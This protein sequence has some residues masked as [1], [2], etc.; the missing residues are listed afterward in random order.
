MLI[1]LYDLFQK[2]TW[3]IVKQNSVNTN[4]NQTENQKN[5]H[6]RNTALL[7]RHTKIKRRLPIYLPTPKP[8]IQ[9]KNPKN[10]S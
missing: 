1:D 7:M 8:S 4:I 3:I 9:Q 5:T 6:N 10:S 2:K